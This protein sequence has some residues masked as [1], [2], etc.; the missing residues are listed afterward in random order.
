MY[1]DQV[2]S[3]A[4]FLSGKERSL[5]EI[6][7]HLT[8]VVLLPLEIDTVVLRQLNSS[9]QVI[10]VGRSGIGVKELEK[11]SLNI[12]LQDRWPSS[13]AIRNRKIIW[14]NTLPDW[15]EDYPELQQLFDANYLSGMSYIAFPIYLAR[16]PIASMIII[17][18]VLLQ[19]TAVIERF[20]ETI[21]NIFSMYYYR[22]TLSR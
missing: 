21:G 14:I 13:D 8:R 1:M 10:L 17:S 4:T 7:D 6:L 19:P 11:I 22:N 2:S 20:L 15:G 12:N 9:N 18:R 3:F 16:T 5:Q